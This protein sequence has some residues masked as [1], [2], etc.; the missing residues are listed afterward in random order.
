MLNA[1]AI[2]RAGS[3]VQSPGLAAAVLRML[4]LSAMAMLASP[5]KAA[6]AGG[7]HFGGGYSDIADVILGRLP[8]LSTQALAP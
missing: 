4:M 8:K 5:F 6:N 3:T 1:T 2:R 7:H